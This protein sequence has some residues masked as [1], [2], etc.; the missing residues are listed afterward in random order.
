MP[1]VKFDTLEPSGTDTIRGIK[2]VTATADFFNDHFPRKPIL[3]GVMMLDSMI[4]LAAAGAKQALQE[5]QSDKKPVLRRTRKVK[6]RRF[7][8]P[9]DQLCME[10]SKR[11]YDPG[12]SAYTVTATV[13]GKKAASL[14][15]EFLHLDK[16][17][18]IAQYL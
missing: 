17:D 11:A 6:F 1:Y 18:Y 5:Q 14:S 15:I 12:G 2:N 9:G 3:P 7:V 8:Q 13:N 16:A 10:A 4:G